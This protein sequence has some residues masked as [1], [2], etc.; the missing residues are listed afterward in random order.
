MAFSSISG[1]IAK[2]TIAG[3]GSFGVTK[4]EAKKSYVN[5][6]VTVTQNSW[7][8]FCPIVRG[9]ILDVSVPLSSALASWIDDAFDGAEFNNAPTI[10]GLACTLDSN[11]AAGEVYIGTGLIESYNIIYDAKDAAR[12][13]FTIRMTGEVL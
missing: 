12:L 7:E 11:P 3:V 10:N 5:A 8:Q 13:V 9:M 6:D 4:I 1:Q 2:L